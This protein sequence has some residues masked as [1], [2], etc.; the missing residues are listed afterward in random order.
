M[1]AAA[2]APTP[3]AG[4]AFLPSIP[5]GAVT[6]AGQGGCGAACSPP[7]RDVVRLGD[8]YDSLGKEQ[9]SL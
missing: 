8:I 4:P 3:T 9:G 2:C 1:L 5:I 7:G 6:G